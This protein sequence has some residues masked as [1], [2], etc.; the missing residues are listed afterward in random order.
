MKWILRRDFTMDVP[1]RNAEH[2]YSGIFRKFRLQLE[3]WC[4]TGKE[5]GAG[6]QDMKYYLDLQEKRL[7]E[8]DLTM[9]LDMESDQE[10]I[11]VHK[12]SSCV[13]ILGNSLSKFDRSLYTQPVNRTVTFFRQGKKLFQRKNYVSMYQTIL[14][15][16]PGNKHIGKSTYVCPNCSAISTLEVL[17]D[18]G[19]PY[20]GTRYLMK[21]LY[22]KVTNYYYVDSGREDK[23]LRADIKHIL[24]AA[25]CCGIGQ[26]IY[27]FLTDAE[28]GL[29]E[30]VLSIPLAFALWTG[31]LYFT[32]SIGLL[33]WTFT[34]AGKAISLVGAT[35]G[36]KT[37]ITRKLQTC[38]PAFDYEYF[39]GK[40]LSLARI[41][42]LS[43]HP[44][45]CVQYQGPALSDRFSDV[46][47]IE[48]RGG[49]GVHS[50]RKS[51]EWI[52]MVLDLY[53]TNT[54]D[55]GGKLK[56]KDERIRINMYHNAAFPVDET[57]SIVK[58]QCPHCSSSFDARKEKNC[59]SCGQPYD[60]GINDWVVTKISR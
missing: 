25:A 16:D 9:E 55:C 1:N 46:V 26:I 53:L 47:D 11:S 30:A 6:N 22:P 35:A 52:E 24:M 38:D 48:Y 50:I 3:N 31:A 59:P 20:C 60:A 33:I 21:D 49:I 51:K 17:Q 40:A 32:Y 42:M 45:D 36:S 28:F 27:T 23:K 7:K 58:V 13:P 54:L 43:E 8:H 14:S 12:N 34:K 57:F 19:C 29:L 15:P 56:Q 18:T 37:K 10:V 41:L 2:E 4:R 5:P 39:E 44:E